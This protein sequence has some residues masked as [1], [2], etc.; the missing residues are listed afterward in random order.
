MTITTLTMNDLIL[1]CPFC[2]G[3]GDVVVLEDE[4]VPE[5]E[6]IYFVKCREC[7]A[8]GSS[9]DTPFAALEWWNRE[10]LADACRDREM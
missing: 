8:N 3:P 2:F 10:H 9:C 1:P 5:L 4:L 7:S 6:P